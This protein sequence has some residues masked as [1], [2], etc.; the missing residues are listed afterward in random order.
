MKTRFY[1]FIISFVMLVGMIPLNLFAVESD[2]QATQA[3]AENEASLTESEDVLSSFASNADAELFTGLGNKAPDG[4]VVLFEGEHIASASLANGTGTYDAQTGAIIGTPTAIDK[5]GGPYPN[6]TVRHAPGFAQDGWNTD[7]SPK[8]TAMGDNRYQVFST[9]IRRGEAF[10]GT[11]VI[12]M[13]IY[14]TSDTAPISSANYTQGT[15]RK[16]IITVKYNA[17]AQALTDVNGNVICSFGTETYTNFIIIVDS[18][19]NT[20]SLYVNGKECV[21]SAAISVGSG[22]RIYSTDFLTQDGTTEAF[23][24]VHS[25]HGAT[26]SYYTDTLPEIPEK[27][28]SGVVASG[29]NYYYYEDGMLITDTTVDY[30]GYKLELAPY[31]GRIVNCY[32]A[33]DKYEALSYENYQTLIENNAT[34]QKLTMT[35]D[36]IVR[37]GISG[38][39]NKSYTSNGVASKSVTAYRYA[40]DGTTVEQYLISNG[41]EIRFDADGYQWFTLG[42]KYKDITY[43]SSE[44]NLKA[45]TATT[46]NLDFQFIDAGLKNVR[47]ATDGDFVIHYP[48]TFGE[49]VNTL[50]EDSVRIMIMTVHQEESQTSSQGR[51]QPDVLYLTKNAADG[52]VHL[53][54]FGTDIG[55]VEIGTR[56]D[57]AFMGSFGTNAAGTPSIYFDVY[58]NGELV[59][60]NYEYSNGTAGVK[61]FQNFG[62]NIYK[63]GWEGDLFTV[64]PAVAYTGNKNLTAM[65]DGFTGIKNHEDYSIYYEN[66]SIA[67]RGTYAELSAKYG[68]AGVELTN[69]NVALNDVLNLNF[70][71]NL[72]SLPLD[73]AYAKFTVGDEVQT[74]KLSELA[75]TG[76]LYK[77]SAK[78]SSIE[79][80]VD[81]K[82]EIFDGNG[83]PVAIN[84]GQ[85]SSY[86]WTYSIRRYCEYVIK[87]GAEFTPEAIKAAKVLLLYG[88]MAE[89][90][91]VEG[92]LD[93]STA[94]AL[95]NYERLS[96]SYHEIGDTATLVN[97][98]GFTGSG[99]SSVFTAEK[100]ENIPV[101]LVGYVSSEGFAGD[102]YLVLDTAIKIR[103]AL[104]V[105]EAPTTVTGGRLVSRAEDGVTKYYVDIEGLTATDLNTV[106]EVTIDGVTIRISALAV[107]N[108]ILS[109]TDGAYT[110][111]F[112][113]L[114]RAMLAYYYYVSQYVSGEYVYT[115]PDA[116]IVNKDGKSG[117]VTFVLDDGAVSTAKIAEELLAKYTETTATFALI[118]DKLADFQL[119]E[120][121]SEY[122]RDENG[123][124]VLTQTASQV[125][126]TEYWQN[127]VKAYPRVE[128]T[129]HSHTHSYAGEN[130][131]MLYVATDKDGK[132]YVFPKGS[133]SA[134]VYGSKQIIKEL[135]GRDALGFVIPGGVVSAE[136]GF[137][138]D[139]W[140]PLVKDAYLGARGTKT[141]TNPSS[142]VMDSTFVNNE[143]TLWR[144][145]A[146]MVAANK[147][148]L[149]ASGEF[150]SADTDVQTLLAA[151]ITHAEN[152]MNVAMSDGKWACFCIHAIVEAGSTGTSHIYKE[153]ADALFAYANALS[154]TGEAWVAN[155]SDALKYYREWNASTL[156]V[157][158]NGE[159]SIEVAIEC[160]DNNENLDMALT[161]KINVPRSWD[162][163]EF[164]YL[165]EVL[166]LEVL[167]DEDGTSFVY[168][169]VLPNTEEGI[170]RA[171]I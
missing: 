16:T 113:D 44:A 110:D 8:R 64:T 50:T 19:T 36:G 33:I 65:T 124:F 71:V 133:V 86:S 62:I 85:D 42:T 48:I 81:V 122:K 160:T 80:D 111:D 150:Y 94:T 82:L 34:A 114:A 56:T 163:V 32:R 30:K 68:S 134:E 7:K 125:S 138:M 57:F 169:N 95:T 130:D 78:L 120:D 146:Y 102:V 91:F 101:N 123:N 109:D 107:A 127:L 119:S 24:G 43:Y 1:A 128:I 77:L 72:D 170:L 55:P 46:T 137:T 31:S 129:S 152:F 49:G 153:Q 171:G 84:R 61:N 47:T 98:T 26:V 144:T 39:S 88:A 12:R 37:T 3:T 126:T 63:A 117:T 87:N 6:I 27:C 149:N 142:M 167:K 97:V 100:I 112:K 162:T 154:L 121:G 157:N 74:V 141:T 92:K 159:E 89:R 13:Q 93:L 140:W 52:K 5:A 106:Y 2:S 70:Y 108:A 99:N 21:S 69:Y 148:A 165:G 18:E 96:A 116:R 147:M 67:E 115:G 131:S 9:N 83:N 75:K 76:E 143:T 15:Y 4:A 29:E 60:E 23:A 41:C 20:Y 38:N 145:P 58:L 118:T 158:A 28:A 35:Y 166:T 168:C 25:Y 132:E 79:M 59:V 45:D 136:D 11:N 105:T 22:Y 40:A 17:E 139:A 155:Y 53:E 73:G 164:D 161:V 104:N 10:S 54:V 66:G 90:N 14:L 156:K 151:G 135:L 103:I 51:K